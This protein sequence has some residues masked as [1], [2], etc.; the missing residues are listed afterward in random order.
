MKV[1]I[2]KDKCLGC[3]ACLVIASQVFEIGQDGKSKVKE[4]VNLEKK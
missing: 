3:G 1:K 2:N 4:G